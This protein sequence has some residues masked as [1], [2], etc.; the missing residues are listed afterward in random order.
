MRDDDISMLYAEVAKEVPI[1]REA[2]VDSLKDWTVEPIMMDG[3]RIGVLILR[4]KEIHMHIVKQEAL[5]HARRIIKYYVQAKLNE[6]GFLVTR[7]RGSEWDSRFLGRLGFRETHRDG[8][9]VFYRLDKL[10]LK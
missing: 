8:T 6:L 5:R 9:E 2:Y 1:S 7:S 3:E 10:A 4:D